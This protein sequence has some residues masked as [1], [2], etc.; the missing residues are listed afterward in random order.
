MCYLKRAEKIENVASIKTS[1][2][3]RSS[4]TVSNHTATFTDLSRNK[5][6]VNTAI[7]IYSEIIFFGGLRLN[8]GG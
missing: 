1:V 3:R 6:G 5:F 2:F 7:L 4:K 8:D